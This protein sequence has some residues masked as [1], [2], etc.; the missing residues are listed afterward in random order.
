MLGIIYFLGLI[1]A[2]FGLVYL[3]P[4]VCS[5]VTGDGLWSTF[6]VCAT[7]TST[8]GTGLA[9]LTFKYRRELKPRDGFMLVTVGW[10]LLAVAATLPLMMAMPGL[11]FARA[12]F[13]TM[14]GLTTTGS[15]V[16]TGLDSLAPSL[17]FWR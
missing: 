2:A 16:F 13:E 1:L 8:I 14:S 15:T 11:T 4:I 5:L 6:L 7:L 17:N 12:L 3:L 10:I 9:A